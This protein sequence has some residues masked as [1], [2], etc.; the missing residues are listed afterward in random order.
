MD[1]KYSLII[2]WSE[3]DRC[4]LAWVPEFGVAS[5]VHGESYEEAAKAGREVIESI[6]DIPEEERLHSP[7][8]LYEGPKE[9][10]QIGRAILPNNPAYQPP[11][12]KT[13]AVA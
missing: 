1:A 13:T 6:L 9:D 4:Y 11:K 7:P 12:K 8:W 3:E 5:K 10:S 2:R